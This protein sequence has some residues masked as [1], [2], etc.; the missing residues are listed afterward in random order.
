MIQRLLPQGGEPVALAYFTLGTIQ[1]AAGHVPA[2][3]QSYETALEANRKVRPAD[4]P[5]VLACMS[6][7]ARA[8]YF[9]GRSDKAL[10]L[11]EDVL[12]VQE[13]TLGRQHPETL[14]TIGNVGA[15]YMVTGRA[16]EALPL[17]EEVWQNVQRYPQL[18][19]IEGHLFKAYLA[20]GDLPKARAVLDETLKACRAT[21]AK[22]GLE[23]ATRL[24]VVGLELIDTRDWDAAEELL[25]EALAIRERQEPDAWTTF[26]TKSAL[27]G[28][29]LGAA[30]LVEAEPLLLDGYRGMK[31]REARIPTQGAFRVLQALE[32]LVLLCEAKGDASGAAAWRERLEASRAEGAKR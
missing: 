10:T 25:R 28:A 31:A 20:A 6:S 1:E 24:T 30:K 4:H 13:T 23:L 11:Y 2:A 8:Y 12:R 9:V 29:L 19:F 14:M 26:N 5:D 32:R 22:G 27:G 15:N 17:L 18:R 3:V 7:L 21:L 16:Q